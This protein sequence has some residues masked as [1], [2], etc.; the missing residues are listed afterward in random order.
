MFTEREARRA[1]AGYR[2]RGLGKL[3]RQIVAHALESGVEGARVL[4]I[5][6]GIGAIQAELLGDGAASGEVVELVAAYEQ[7]ARSLAE[8]KGLTGQTSFRVADVLA[9]PET[10]APADVV[11]LNRVVCC[12]PDGVELAVV[13]ARLAR[14]SLVLTFPRNTMLVRL[15]AGFLNGG[16][17]LL[18]RSF[19]V[20][21]HAPSDLVAAAETEGLRLAN[22]GGNRL[23]ELVAFERVT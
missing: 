21:V 10:V 8:E 20:F 19:R 14:R 11:V 16:C 1:L 4:E 9:D 18:R 7:Y 5:G 17:R 22:R 23:W 12:S 2:R 15:G 13:A 6:G 3:E